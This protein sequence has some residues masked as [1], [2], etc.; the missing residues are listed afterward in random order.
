MFR[1]QFIRSGHVDSESYG[2]ASSTGPHG[3]GPGRFRPETNYFI[4]T[5]YLKQLKRKEKTI[6]LFLEFQDLK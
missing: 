6:R 4:I 3:D 1:R 5:I 2:T